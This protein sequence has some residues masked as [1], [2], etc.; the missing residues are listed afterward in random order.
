MPQML[1]DELKGV[2]NDNVCILTYL[3]R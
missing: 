2:P 3:H 1:L